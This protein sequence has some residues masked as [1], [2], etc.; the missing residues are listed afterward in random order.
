MFTDLCV[1]FTWKVWEQVA[2]AMR[3]LYRDMMLEIYGNLLSGSMCSSPLYLTFRP[4]I[5]SDVILVF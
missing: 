1:S 5:L 4:R 2:L 3:A